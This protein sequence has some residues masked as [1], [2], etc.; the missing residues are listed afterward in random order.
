MPHAGGG[1]QGFIGTV[2]GVDE[3]VEQGLFACRG[4][5]ARPKQYASPPEGSHSA[6]SLSGGA[7]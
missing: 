5:E 1:K 7:T 2:A 4:V 3:G 6:P